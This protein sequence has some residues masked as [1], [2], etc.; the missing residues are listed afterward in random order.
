M[1]T[2]FQPGNFVI[3]AARPG[4]GKTSFALNMAVAA[5]RECGA[6]IAFFSLEMS[7]N[8]LIQRL[9]CSEARISMNDM[10]RGN[11]KPHQWEEISRAMGTLNELP[12]YLDDLGA[13][14]VS[15]VRS[16]CRRLKS[17]VGLGCDLHRL[18]AARC[19]PACSRAT[20]IATK[21]FRRSAAR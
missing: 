17:T 2:G 21:S 18:P 7:N 6:P 5:A 11:I 16:R 12:I 14:T 13:L 3:V 8:E 20:P 19:A 1:T 10:R 15:D 9:I 4:M